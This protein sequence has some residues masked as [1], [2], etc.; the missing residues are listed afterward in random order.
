MISL[1]QRRRGM[2][3]ELL[4]EWYCQIL[5]RKIGNQSM[6]DK[7]RIVLLPVNKQEL[8]QTL[9]ESITNQSIIKPILGI[10]SNRINRRKW[11]MLFVHLWRWTEKSF[12]KTI[13][14][15]KQVRSRSRF[16][17][18]TSK[19]IACW[20]CSVI[21]HPKK[22]SWWLWYYSRIKVLFHCSLWQLI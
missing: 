12:T 19:K 10:E 17:K 16:I 11:W 9:I 13:P 8:K 2:H 4:S 20:H 18:K 7:K 22:W 15:E 14:Q 6:I 21:L 3:Y 5:V 1:W